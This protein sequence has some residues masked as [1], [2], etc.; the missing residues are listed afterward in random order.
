MTDRPDDQLPDGDLSDEKMADE[1]DDELASAYLDGEVSAAE[2]ARVENDPGLR[3]RV[4]EL[5]DASALVGRPVS[6]PSDEAREAA[7][8]RALDAAG[9]DDETT[10]GDRVGAVLDLSA[11]RARRAERLR[12][13]VAAAAAIAV[14]GL[15]AFALGRLGG[16]D[17]TQSADGAGSG[18]EATS[19]DLFAP[20]GVDLG[21]VADDAE[22]RG[23]LAEE[24]GLG[25]LE[26]GGTAEQGLD[27]AAEAAPADAADPEPSLEA[28]PD[29]D[30]FVDGDD[31]GDGLDDSRTTSAASGDDPVSRA[32]EVEDCEVAVVAANRDLA[33]RLLRAAAT[34]AGTPAEVFAFGDGTGS[35]HVIV[36][37]RDSCEQL[38]RFTLPGG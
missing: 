26:A 1:R 24:A 10:A 20:E 11:A 14:V 23:R 32:T 17:A 19:A 5:R 30:S 29:A 31:T 22:L 21:A 33:G 38:S 25:S 6:P 12:P 35:V 8:R 15:G 18:E 36:V 13:L 9:A 27:E 28:A 7:I 16:D 37:E 4:E 34:Y 3:R 2:R